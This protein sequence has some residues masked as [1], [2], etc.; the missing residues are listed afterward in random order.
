MIPALQ[1]L[2]KI[3]S[4]IRQRNP[5]REK[6]DTNR[7]QIGIDENQIQN[8]PLLLPLHSS[9]AGIILKGQGVRSNGTIQN[10]GDDVNVIMFKRSKEVWNQAVQPATG[11][12]AAPLNEEPFLFPACQFPM[13]PDMILEFQQRTA[14]RTVRLF[15]AHY[16]KGRF[17]V[18]RLISYTDIMTMSFDRVPGC[19]TAKK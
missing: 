3:C 6:T 15:L 18:L 8:D 1:F 2:H 14:V 5:N 16:R 7:L 17:S 12:A 4:G 10:S 11:R 13:P 9:L 19:T